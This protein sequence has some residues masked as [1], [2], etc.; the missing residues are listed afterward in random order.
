MLENLNFQVSCQTEHGLSLNPSH[1]V[2]VDPRHKYIL[3]LSVHNS[4][5]CTLLIEFQL[6][7]LPIP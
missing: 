1:I 4:Y 6:F 7:I 5:I 3:D 2:L